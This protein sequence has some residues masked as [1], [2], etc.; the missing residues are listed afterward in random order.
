MFSGRYLAPP[1][2]EKAQQVAS[3]LDTM[4][5][6][7]AASIS[8]SGKISEVFSL[9]SKNTDI[10]RENMEK[11]LKGKIVQWTLPVYEVRKTDENMYRVQTKSGTRYVGAF[12]T[13]HT[14]SVE[15]SAYV[16]SLRTGNMI[17]F[18]GRINGTTMR[19]IDVD[20]AVLVS[21]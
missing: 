3:A 14:R 21:R 4:A 11:E 19:N 8:P 7:Q 5:N 6:A 13:L 12:L 16:E 2:E 20:P 10:Q 15:E 1:K 9:G 17:S 18:K